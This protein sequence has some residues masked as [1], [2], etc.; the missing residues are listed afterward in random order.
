M[1]LAKSYEPI[2]DLKI[3]IVCDWL[4]NMGGA[5]RVV[6]EMHK[7][8]PSA[9]IYTSTY[10]PERMP[11]FSKITI[12]TAWFQKLPRFMRKHQLLTLPRQWYF[13]R[14]K[15]KGYDVVL[16]SSGAEA[17]AV[18]NKN[19]VHINYC[20]TPTQYYWVRPKEYLNASS[21]GL[22]SPIY[23]LGLKLLMP[24]MKRW[25]IKASKRPDYIIANST[26]VQ[27][28]IKK[29]YGLDS[30]VI[31]PPVDTVRFTPPAK[32]P[33]REGFVIAGRQVHHKRFDIAIRACN[34]LQLPLTV[35]GTGPEHK[36]LRRIAGKT[37]LFKTGVSDDQLPSFFHKSSGFIFPNEEDFGIVA[38]EAMAAGCPLVAFKAGGA[39]DYVKENVSGVF[40]DNQNVESLKEALINFQ[41]RHF[42]ED[43]VISQAK[44][45]D[46]LVFR[47]KLDN[48]IFEKQP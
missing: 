42:S 44:L 41:K 46:S 35:I 20:H 24:H 10:E 13:S 48:F 33:P 15:L 45:F 31:H 28:R 3:A 34:E 6:L 27:Q 18:R 14:L 17:K 40:F 2:K 12:H 23:R 36:A 19:G 4:T 1:P 26:I 38:V 39:L 32:K 25:D 37:I 8:F 47:E 7:L 29:I 9:P 30:V 5:E 16:S 11:L 43:R 22:L 21:V